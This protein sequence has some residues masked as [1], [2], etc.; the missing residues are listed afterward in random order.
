SVTLTSNS[1]RPIAMFIPKKHISRRTVLRGMGVALTL[2]MLEAMTPAQTPSR[3]TALNGKT[4][5]I[6]IEN[7]HGAGGSCMYGKQMHYWQPVK[8]GRDFEMSLSLA[9]L[10]PFKQHITIVSDSDC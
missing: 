10:E 4:K 2:P 1:W 3:Q 6:A 7:P 5:F 8:E 9:P